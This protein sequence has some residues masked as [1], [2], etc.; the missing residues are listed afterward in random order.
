VLAETLSGYVR[1]PFDPDEVTLGEELRDQLLG[2]LP[3]T[4][5]ATIPALISAAHLAF[6]ERPQ[7]AL[8][9]S[10]AI[11]AAL[12]QLPVPDVGR[13]LFRMPSHGELQ[14]L[15][16]G[17]SWQLLQDASFST[18]D[19]ASPLDHPANQNVW[20]EWR[21]HDRRHGFWHTSKQH[22]A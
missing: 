18:I 9:I 1:A 6:V 5:T 22:L 19:A 11:Q 10:T 4:P 3:L 17:I 15:V 21:A 2:E 16:E 20:L 13:Q 7:A 12:T 8:R 14:A